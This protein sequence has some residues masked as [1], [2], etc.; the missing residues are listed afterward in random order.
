VIEYILVILAFLIIIVFLKIID[1]LW[2]I[3][4]LRNQEYYAKYY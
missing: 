4:W 2:W 3:G 1:E